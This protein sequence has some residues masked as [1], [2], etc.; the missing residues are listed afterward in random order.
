MLPPQRPLEPPAALA[1]ALP[2]RSRCLP[3][4]AARLAGRPPGT[5]RRLQCLE[6]P[7]LELPALEPPALELPALDLP[8]LELP[9]LELPALKLPALEL[10][11]PPLPAE[12]VAACRQ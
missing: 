5:H 3:A 7:A 12:L 1:P 8:A 6:L 4:S 9:A 11:A 10:P 2:H